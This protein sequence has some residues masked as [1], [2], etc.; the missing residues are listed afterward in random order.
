[1]V[2]RLL[3]QHMQYNNHTLYNPTK[4]HVRSFLAVSVL[5]FSK[6]LSF[7]SCRSWYLHFAHK[8]F[9]AELPTLIFCRHPNIKMVVVVRTESVFHNQHL[10]IWKNHFA[11]KRDKHTIDSVNCT[12]SILYIFAT[13]GDSSVAIGGAIQCDHY[14]KHIY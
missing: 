12:E 6:L 5:L 4:N 8:I 7:S 9:P 2:V 1:M 10:A 3:C 14:G 13:C 11:P